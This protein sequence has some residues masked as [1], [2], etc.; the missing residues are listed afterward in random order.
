[1]PGSS[2]HHAAAHST[3]LQRCGFGHDW[4]AP[5]IVF[6]CNKKINP[7][8]PL[9]PE[10]VF[11]IYR[12]IKK[13]RKASARVAVLPL[14]PSNPYPSNPYPSNPY[15]ANT[16]WPLYSAGGYGA[17]ALPGTVLA[18]HPPYFTQ[19][20]AELGIQRGG[21]DPGPSSAKV[22]Y[23]KPTVP[24][25]TAQFYEGT[26]PPLQTPPPSARNAGRA[27]AAPPMSAAHAAKSSSPKPMSRR[28]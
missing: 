17:P 24:G 1:M 22:F 16:A 13:R 5:N 23:K 12:L 15:P 21:S 26:A 11:F 25:P 7:P 18:K 20:H 14:D 27:A 10:V 4:Y 6:V 3:R 8:L 9:P 2:G 19:A 28:K